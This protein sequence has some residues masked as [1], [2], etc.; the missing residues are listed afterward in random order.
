MNERDI[1]VLLFRE[2][3]RHFGSEYKQ[4]KVRVSTSTITQASPSVRRVIFRKVILL[5][6]KIRA[7]FYIIKI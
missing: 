7:R 1:H 4:S 3:I 5:H 2:S 6:W